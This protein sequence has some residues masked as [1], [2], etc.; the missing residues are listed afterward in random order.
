[1]YTGSADGTARCWVTEFGD[2]T[3][4]YKGHDMSVTAI[5]FYKGLG[6]AKALYITAHGGP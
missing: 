2:N 1:M 4:I 3:A 5:K 6:K